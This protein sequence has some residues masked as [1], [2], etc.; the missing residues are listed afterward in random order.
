VLLRN[1][2]PAK[3]PLQ[4]GATASAEAPIPDH[5]IVGGGDGA[6]CLLR[7]AQEPSAAN[8]KRLKPMGVVASVRLEGGVSSIVVEGGA[9]KGGAFSVLVGTQASNIYRV[10]YD[11]TACK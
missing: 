7:T 1:T 10:T 11:A 6:L 3:A 4:R 9:G 5:L 8:P 2:G